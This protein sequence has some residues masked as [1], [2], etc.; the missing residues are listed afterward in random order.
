MSIEDLDAPMSNVSMSQGPAH[1]HDP[2]STVHRLL[3]AVA[4]IAASACA[5]P[6][7]D[8][9]PAATASA[10][11]TG[12]PV[13]FEALQALLP[14]V[15]GWTRGEM[16]GMVLSVPLRGTQASLQLTRGDAAMS[17]EIIDTVFNQALY[18]PVAAYLADGFTSSTDGDTTRAVKV[19]GQPAFEQ[20][21]RDGQTAAVT[22]L[23]GQRFLV[24]VQTTGVPDM[25]S[26][27]GAADA[28]DMAKLAA[29]T[30]GT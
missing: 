24:R 17:I 30:T 2:R 18:A 21:T 19:Q 28:I 9:T 23:V 27:R 29:L 11:H 22:V 8:A 1:P 7:S 26:A 10:L 6:A 3:V 15:P 14:T 16:T 20:F 25:T 13:P 4:L 12:T 5:G